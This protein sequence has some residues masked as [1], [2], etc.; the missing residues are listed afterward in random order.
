[1]ADFVYCVVLAE[2]SRTEE[3]Q[4]DCVLFIFFICWR[5]WSPCNLPLIPSKDISFQRIP[6]TCNC[7]VSPSP[8]FAFKSYP[9]PNYI[10]HLLV[11]TYLVNPPFYFLFFSALF[12][13]IGKSQN[14]VFQRC[15][16]PISITSHI[17]SAWSFYFLFWKILCIKLGCSN[18]LY[19]LYL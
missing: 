17:F 4:F 6:N 19:F 14:W 12:L 5:Q 18:W 1:M 11:L 7:C 16:S 2:Q 10:C 9:P 8:F 3:G 13:L 15:L